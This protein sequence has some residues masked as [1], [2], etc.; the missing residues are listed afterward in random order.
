MNEY[1][2]DSMCWSFVGFTAGYLVCRIE[3]LIH[4]RR[5]HRDHS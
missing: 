1:L 2:T 5:R 4:E 3:V